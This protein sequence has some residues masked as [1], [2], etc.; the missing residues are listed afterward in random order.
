MW[1]AIRSFRFAVL[2]LP[3]SVSIFE[4]SAQIE[5][6]AEFQP[7]RLIVKFKTGSGLLALSNTPQN[8]APIARVTTLTPLKLGAGQ[9]IQ[10][11][12][13]G[14]ERIFVAQIAENDNL[15]DVLRE[16]AANPD[17]EY[18]EPDYLG[19]G[20]GG[21]VVSSGDRISAAQVPTDPDFSWQWGMHNTG[22]PPF[23]GTPGIDVDILPAWNITS[24]DSDTILAMLDSGIALDHPDFAGR[25]LPG[26]NFVDERKSPADDLGHG[27]N[28]SS[29]AAATGGNGIG[30][31]G[32]NWKCRIL[33]VKILNA[34]NS[35][36]YSWFASGFIYAA[37]QGAKVI[38]ISAGGSSKSQ[39]LADAVSYAQARGVI[40]VAC[41]MNTNDETPFYPA[42]YP[43]VI[44]IGAVDPKG[45]RVVPFC[46]NPTTGSNFGSHIAFVAPGNNILGLNYRDFTQTSYMCGTS[47]ATPFV[48]GL[49]SLMFAINSNLTLQQVTDALKAGARDQVGPAYEDTPG[50]DKYF[51]WGLIDAYKSLQAVPAPSSIY[52]P[53]MAIGGGFTSTFTLVNTGVDAASGSLMLI[54][55]EGTPLQATLSSADYAD[56]VGSSF[57]ISVP[58]RGS[59]LIT[60]SAQNP[61]D[62]T[63]TGWGR[64]QYSGGSLEGVATFQLMNGTTLTTIVGVLS[65]PAS[66]TG[67]IPIDDDRTLGSLSRVTGYAVANPGQEEININLLLLSPDGSVSRAIDPSALNPLRPGGHVARFLWE[68]L[69]E[70]DLQF[71]GS[72][73]LTAQAAK[74]F[75]TVALVMNQGLFTAIPVVPSEQA[76]PAPTTNM[77]AQVAVGDGFS[78]IFTLSNTGT[79]TASGNLILAGDDGTPLTV[80]F[81]SP[82]Q[83]NAVSSSFPVNV[84]SGG[85]QLITASAVNPSETIRTGWARA[86]GTGGLVRGVATFQVVKENALKTIAGVLSSGATN[87]ATIPVNDNNT[88]GDK[89]YTTGYAVA[90]PGSEDIN[91]RIT[92]L[93]ADGS[94]WKILDPSLLNP[95]R[96]GSHVAR[97]LWQDLNDSIIQFR[98]SMVLTAQAA[99]TFA[100]VALVMNQSQ[101]T[102]IPVIPTKGPESN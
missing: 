91:I 18:A 8:R 22:Q 12:P 54:G 13:G 15:D 41:M 28:C 96:P 19:H 53:Q 24:G 87:S 100:V 64:I 101:F 35:G 76:S 50:W 36:S 80:A 7:H 14:V 30:I 81:V 4:A 42:A 74:T 9:R 25:I 65:S 10:A 26:K 39:A 94:I 57:P 95:L 34:N 90:N 73:V 88:L 31:A 68:D 60:A 23:A 77:F 58:S 5:R 16:L 66:A 49:V 71:R 99:K 98:G 51:G 89:S 93:N 62:S 92:V 11:L 45:S 72:V 1:P 37:D 47:Q 67:R 63:Q 86:E 33:P 46:Y 44:A 3:L 59:Q 69:N 102:A 70:P 85:M 32:M 6:I 75:A 20:D 55:D 79:E 82:G 61:N 84:P 40:V 48:S 2:F 21:G 17:V 56:R 27:T 43:G 78:T 29:I 38:S 52:F 83:A 97:F